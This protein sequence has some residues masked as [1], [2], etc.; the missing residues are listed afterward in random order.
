[1]IQGF[2]TGVLIYA[3]IVLAGRVAAAYLGEPQPKSTFGGLA[4]CMGFGAAGA[5]I[6]A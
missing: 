5:L 4:I 6:A 2:L 3:I 1:M